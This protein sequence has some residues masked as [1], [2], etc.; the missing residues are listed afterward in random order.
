MRLKN[1]VGVIDSDYR[2]EI[3]IVCDRF[4]AEEEVIDVGKRVAQLLIMPVCPFA[5]EQ[6]GNYEDLTVTSRDV[7]GF[8]STGE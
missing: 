5:V 1:T 8:G 2:G 3:L 4:E 6:V 7:G